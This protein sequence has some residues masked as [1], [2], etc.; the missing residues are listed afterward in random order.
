MTHVFHRNTKLELPVAVGGEG[1]YLIDRD[2]NR[3]IDGSSGAAVSSLGHNDPEIVAAIKDQ[4]DTLAYAHTQFFTTEIMETLADDLVNDA[5]AGIDK[6]YFTSGGAEAVESAVKLAREYFVKTGEPGRSHIISRQ[7]SYHGTT[8]GALSVAGHVQRREPFLPLLVDMTHI[9]P[10]FAYRYQQA[11]ESLEDY[12]QRAANELEAA[13]ERIGAER[14]AAFV[15]EPVV[16]ATTGAVT[17]APG[18]FKRV[19][20][21]CDRHGVLL[22]LD[23]V[24]CGMGRCGTLHACAADDVLPDILTV[25]KGLAAGYAP[26][27]AV[28]VSSRVF[29][30][31]DAT[32]GVFENGFTFSGH[33]LACAAALAV[34]RAIKDRNLLDNVRARGAQLRHGLEA[35]FGDNQHVGDIRGR[36]LF[37]A[38]EL[39][40]DRGTKEPFDP[41]LAMFARVK[42]EGIKRGLISYPNGG[43]VDG[44]RGD[45]VLM[46]PPFIVTESDIGEIVG[47]LG[48]AVDAAI[49]S[50]GA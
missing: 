17:A 39:V 2:G 6:V 34:Q 9:A 4:A 37:Q 38:I 36:G 24:M 19:R 20:E 44:K 22:I 16:G 32:N 3:F 27:G 25:A 11:D 42:N 50:A 23:E 47:R 7:Q 10:C 48:E 12:G 13:I 40:R 14:V 33:A 30:A 35:R 41:K 8:I 15:A 18:Y 21:I 43:T 49:A 28:L 31:F 46:A 26:I 5:P 1:I 29:E 45:H